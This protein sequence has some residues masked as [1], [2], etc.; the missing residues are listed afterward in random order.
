MRSV[1]LAT[2]LSFSL[3]VAA[4]PDTG[5][6]VKGWHTYDAMGCMLLK[7]CTEG[8][9]RV[10]NTRDVE[11]I[12]KRDFSAV[13]KEF[14]SISK[15]FD[16]IGINVYIADAKYFPHGHRG[17]YHTV[18]NHFY[19]NEAYVYRPNV[20]MAVVRHEG[21]HAAQD[22]MAGTIDN[23]LIAIIKPEEVVPQLWQDM[24]T[25]TYSLMPKAIPWEKEA[26]WA[27]H[28]EGMTAEALKVCASD[29]PMWKHYTPTPLTR[30][31]LQ[32]N[33]YIE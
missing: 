3:P 4:A 21:W 31:W 14:D 18:S 12:F 33:K 13:R 20:F 19:L 25:R 23:T 8:I 5:K 28:T 27:G 30:K 26:F 16:K 11:R 7:E 15:S 6:I 9:T 10:K 22:C 2:L 1:I 32:E 17:V 29:T 24:A